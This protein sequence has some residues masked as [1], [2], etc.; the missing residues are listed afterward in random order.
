[1]M[2]TLLHP[3]ILA[4]VLSFGPVTGDSR[5]LP[6]S[7]VPASGCAGGLRS[8]TTDCCLS[9]SFDFEPSAPLSTTPSA[10][11]TNGAGSQAERTADDVNVR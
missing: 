6:R 4:L 8:S 1:M 2:V 10:P 5:S 3:A 9:L 7:S 11:A